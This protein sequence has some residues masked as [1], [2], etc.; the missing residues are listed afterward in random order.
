MSPW[1]NNGARGPIEL[2]A[3]PSA[4]NRRQVPVPKRKMSRSN[5]RNRRAQWKAIAPAL[6]LCKKCNLEKIP[7]KVCPNCGSYS[8]RQVTKNKL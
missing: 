2:K 3:F 4:I 1:T 6:E 7:H 5:T 8:N